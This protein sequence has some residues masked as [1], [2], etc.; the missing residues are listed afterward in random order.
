[1]AVRE[2]LL[3]PAHKEALRKESAPVSTVNRQVK[4]LIRDLKDT[5][6]AHSEGV[7]L[8]APQINVHQRVVLVRLG[9]GGDGTCE[10][11]AH[12]ALVNPE[13]IEAGDERKDFDGCLSFPGL[14]AD[15][16]RPHHLRVS[17]LD[18]NGEPFDRCFEGFDAVVAHH[19]I[20][21]LNGVL[22]IDRVERLEDL[23]HIRKD[24]HGIFVRVPVSL[25]LG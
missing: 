6:G 25:E 12:I 20:D 4:R 16:I 24:E 7:G 10:P 19:E 22:F 14:Y 15:T 21:H 5:L 3:Y 17:G 8:A 9:A 13:I 1:M 2:I 11:A 18:E 23:Y